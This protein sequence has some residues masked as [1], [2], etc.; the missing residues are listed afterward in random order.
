MA[1]EQDQEVMPV[2]SSENAE[3]QSLKNEIESLKN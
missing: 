1:G 2:D 3:A